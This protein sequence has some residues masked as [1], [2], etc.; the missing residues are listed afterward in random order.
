MVREQHV[1]SFESLCHQCHLWLKHD[2]WP[3]AQNSAR[4]VDS[5]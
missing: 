1:T 5:M 2:L 3:V 4:H